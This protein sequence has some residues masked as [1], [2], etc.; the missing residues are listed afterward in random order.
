M[1]NVQRLDR[2]PRRHLHELRRHDLRVRPLARDDPDRAVLHHTGVT[3]NF[4]PHGFPAFN[5]SSDLAVWLHNAGYETAL[6]GKYL[7]DYSL[8]GHNEIP[9]GWD[10]WQAMDSVPLE[11]YYDYKVNEN[12]R[13]VHYG[14]A[15]ADYSTTV[16]TSGR[17][18]SCAR[19]GSRSSSTSPR[20]RRTSRR[21]PHPRTWASSTACRR[22]TRRR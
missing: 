7:N 22:S 16:L 17:S 4:G 2:R 21:S 11:K 6:V 20:S 3:D 10:D 15:P 8:D 5:D 14:N 9:P 13:I 19:P 18:P 1:K 12:G